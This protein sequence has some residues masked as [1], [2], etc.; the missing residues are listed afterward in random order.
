[1]KRIFTKWIRIISL[2]YH[3][4]SVGSDLHATPKTKGRTLC[5]DD[6]ADSR[7]LI[8]FVLTR[9][10]Y[11]VTATENSTDALALAKLERFDLLLVDNCVPGVTG[12]DLT[13]QVREFNTSV[14][15]FLLRSG[16][17]I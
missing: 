5:A 7:T 9:K 10:G 13:R 17:G 2:S 8:V 4:S 16:A 12:P 14:P 1:V 11:D 6:D 15:Y 3:W